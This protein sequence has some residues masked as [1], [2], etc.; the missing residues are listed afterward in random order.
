MFDTPESI[1]AIIQNFDEGPKR[2]FSDDKKAQYFVKFGS[3]RDND[4]KHGI[5]KGKL[6]LTG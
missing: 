2:V 1:A 4:P 3:L 6:M 5:Q